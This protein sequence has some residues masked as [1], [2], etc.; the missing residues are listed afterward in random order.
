[1]L[2][3]GWCVSRIGVLLS[4]IGNELPSH[5]VQDHVKL[6]EVKISSSQ[7]EMRGQGDMI[8]TLKRHIELLTAESRNQ[9]VH[10]TSC[11]SVC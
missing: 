3:L 2:I 11:I 6:L 9:E 10:T 4:C 5:L 1:M 8:R 7:E